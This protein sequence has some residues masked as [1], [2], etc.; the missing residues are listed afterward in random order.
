MP[1]RRER[2][3]EFFRRLEQADPCETA[4]EARELIAQTLNAVEDEMTSIPNNP[5]QWETDGRMYPAQDD[6]LRAVPGRPELIRLR[7]KGHETLI[8]DNGAFLIRSAPPQPPRVFVSKPGR[9]GRE[10]Q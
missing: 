10:V 4:Q 1:T 7:H 3:E 2:L 5:S 8:R 6:Q 9:D